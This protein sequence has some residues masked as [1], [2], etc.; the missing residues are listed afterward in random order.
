MTAPFVRI[1]CDRFFGPT[2]DPTNSNTGPPAVWLIEITLNNP[3]AAYEQTLL[4][5]LLRKRCSHRPLGA[6]S[7]TR[8]AIF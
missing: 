8:F 6:T 1:G 7:P 3:H 2:F 4:R 5:Q